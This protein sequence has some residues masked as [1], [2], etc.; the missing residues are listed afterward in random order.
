MSRRSRASRPD[1]TV[2]NA[3]YYSQPA[4]DVIDGRAHLAPAS[5]CTSEEFEKKWVESV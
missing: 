3:A 2:Q 1:R 4:D 5:R